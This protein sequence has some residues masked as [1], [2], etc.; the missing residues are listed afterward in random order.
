MIY[1]FKDQTRLGLRASWNPGMS[2]PNP[3]V[4]A[5]L[6]F[7]PAEAFRP[8]TPKTNAP[9]V[10]GL[11]GLRGLSFGERLIQWGPKVGPAMLPANDF[12]AAYTPSGLSSSHLAS[13]VTWVEGIFGLESA[14]DMLNDA[15]TT[16]ADINQNLN[17]AGTKIQTL[18]SQAQGYN[19]AQNASIQSKA[20]SAQAHAA[21]LI[22]NLSTLQAASSDL[23]VQLLSAKADANTTKDIGGAFKEQADALSTQV[24]TFLDGVSSLDSE[25]KALVKY[26]QSGPSAL[27]S[28]ES[29]IGASVTSSVST[30]TWLVGGG[31][32]VYFLAPTFIPRLVG[33]IRKARRG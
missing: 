19:G 11:F 24:D 26:A 1:G 28:I 12:S 9:R 8:I 33:G 21:G 17:P 23:S 22:A 15:A 29:S 25:V 7:L 14:A 32:L 13:P 31:A 2:E 5:A 20:Q 6:H 18:L 27:E 30:L 3:K 10:S 4:E 16:V